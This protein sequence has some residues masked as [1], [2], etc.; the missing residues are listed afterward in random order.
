MQSIEHP[1]WLI[2]TGGMFHRIINTTW[3]N[4]AKGDIGNKSGIHTWMF[5]WYNTNSSG[6]KISITTY[7][8]TTDGSEDR[9]KLWDRTWTDA[10]TYVPMTKK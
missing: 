5:L 3:A 4:L 9:A 1:I 2:C 6:E 10:Q 8:A 7:E